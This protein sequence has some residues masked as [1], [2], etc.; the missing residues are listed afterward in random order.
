MKC[1]FDMEFIQKY[2]DRILSTESRQEFEQHMEGCPCCRKLMEEDAEVLEFLQEERR[3]PNIPVAAIVSQIDEK[4]YSGDIHKYRVGRMIRKR[5]PQPKVLIPIAGVFI[6]I[7]ILAVNPATVGKLADGIASVLQNR[8]AQ[9]NNIVDVLGAEKDGNVAGKTDEVLVKELNEEGMGVS[10]WNIVYADKDKVFLRSA[11]SLIGYKDGHIYRVAYLK[12]M[13]ATGLQGDEISNLKFSPEGRFVVIGNAYYGGAADGYIAKPVYVV[14]TETGKYREITRQNLANTVDG[15]SPNGRYYILAGKET[16]PDILVYDTSSKAILIVKSQGLKK[17]HKIFISDEGKIAFYADGALVFMDSI[18]GKVDLKV[19][20][21]FTPIF[22]SAQDRTAVFV[23]NGEL[24]KF[25]ADKGKQTLLDNK[26]KIM[27]GAKLYKDFVIYQGEDGT[28]GILNF[29]TQ[30]VSH[31]K[32]PGATTEDF[33]T[34]QLSPDGRKI[35]MERMIS[36]QELGLAVYDAQKEGMT[37]LRGAYFYNSGWMGN[38]VASVRMINTDESFKAG[39]FEIVKYDTFGISPEILYRSDTSGE[40]Q[41]NRTVTNTP[42]AI[43]FSKFIGKG[44]RV[45]ES[46]DEKSKVL[47]GTGY[48]DLEVVEVSNEKTVPGW[49]KVRTVSPVIVEGWVK[50]A[51]IYPNPQDIKGHPEEETIKKLVTDYIRAEYAGD[52]KRLLEITTGESRRE[53]ENG[54]LAGFIQQKLENIVSIRV[55]RITEEEVFV[56][57][58]VSSVTDPKFSASNYQEEMQILKTS[59]NWYINQVQRQQ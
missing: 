12:D 55:S 26:I 17:I 25:N 56:V 14:N 28:I 3:L 29:K 42:K 52:R 35:F 39:M 32:I 11:T 31:V 45:Y 16:P 30:S 44:A 59:G 15:W 24:S 34:L 41:G 5:I 33:L 47:A 7:F 51:E 43:L 58:V 37:E 18:T 9:D 50:S 36:G 19:S 53:I 22:I 1:K 2:N 8:N 13:K 20:V 54:E 4:R 48:A 49:A 27:E 10:P 21:Y 46:A 38:A 6:V 40:S 57:A 23:H